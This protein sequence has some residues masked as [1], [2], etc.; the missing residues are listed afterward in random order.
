MP[1]Y[2]R[3]LKLFVLVLVIVLV[4]DEDPLC[5]S[6]FAPHKPSGIF[7][8]WREKVN[9]GGEVVVVRSIPVWDTGETRV[10]RDLGEY[11]LRI[12]KLADDPNS[13]NEKSSY[14]EIRNQ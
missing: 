2:P 14:G 13:R 4:I 7:S 11:L 5:V 6:A 9:C 10:L 8:D 3:Y 1:I 12:A